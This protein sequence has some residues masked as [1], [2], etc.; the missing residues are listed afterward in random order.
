MTK[1]W[2]PMPFI[3]LSAHE[4]GQY[5]VCCESYDQAQKK[6]PVYFVNEKTPLEFYTSDY[7]NDVRKR[8]LSDNPEEDEI[9]KEV[10]QKCIRSEKT[11]GISKRIR[12]IEELKRSSIDYEGIVDS[13]IEGNFRIETDYVK[14]SSVGNLCNLKCIM[15]GPFSSS[16]ITKEIEENP[17]TNAY[18]S[19]PP[20][21]ISFS[22]VEDKQTWLNDFEKVLNGCRQIQFSGGEPTLIQDVIDICDWIETR[23]NLKNIEIHMNTN[24]TA[25]VRKI[26]H[27]VES[28]RPVSINVSVDGIGAIDEYIRGNTKWDTVKNNL[29][30]YILLS[31]IHTNFSI[32]VNPTIQLCNVG[33]LHYVVDT[34]V[35]MGLYVQPKNFVYWPAH[36]DATILPFKIKEMY[37]EKIHKESNNISLMNEVISVLECKS[38]NLELFKKAI[39]MLDRFDVIRNTNWRELWPEFEEYVN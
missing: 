16:L 1:A 7:V 22:D 11:S 20:N 2:C 19:K 23:P 6:Y 24:G 3:Q 18:D 14:I 4:R 37:L 39:V 15:C 21:I 31:K 27:F 8:M 33:H 10:C 25:P 35:D 30:D 34:I 28:G 36:F 32:G 13:F 9:L 26:E 12:E 29:Y 17:D 38:E 5:K